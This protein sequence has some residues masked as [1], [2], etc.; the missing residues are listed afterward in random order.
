M[1][2]SSHMFWTIRSTA[3]V[4]GRHELTWDVGNLIFVQK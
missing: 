1:Q 2:P 4:L 3:F